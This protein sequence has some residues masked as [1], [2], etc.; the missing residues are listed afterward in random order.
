[1]DL[2][3]VKEGFKP[4][5]H[6]PSQFGTREAR[7]APGSSAALAHPI[8]GAVQGVLAIGREVPNVR[9]ALGQGLRQGQIPLAA[10]DHEGRVSVPRAWRVDMGAVAD[11]KF[12]AFGAGVKLFG[13]ELVGAGVE[14]RIAIGVA[15]IGRGS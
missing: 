2:R 11:Q 15:A 7:S 3:L 12:R 6:V 4:S 10:S 14:R 1:M 9:A 5:R 8:K 13:F